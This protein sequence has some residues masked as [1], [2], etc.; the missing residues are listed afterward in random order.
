VELGWRF[1]EFKEPTI[2]ENPLTRYDSSRHQHVHH[3]RPYVPAVVRL[4]LWDGAKHFAWGNLAESV[5]ASLGP[6]R[7]E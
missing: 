2:D 1:T 6:G 4:V 3:L 5:V 7:E